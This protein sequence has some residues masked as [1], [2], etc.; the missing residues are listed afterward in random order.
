MKKYLLAAAAAATLALLS[1]CATPTPYAPAD[2]TSSRTYRPGYSET[3]LEEGRFRLVFAGND[4]TSRDTVETYLLYRSAELTLTEGYDWFEIVTRDTA[5]KKR[6]VYTDP[7]PS[8]GG[9]SWRYY[10]RSRWTSWGMGF[11]DFDA[12]EYTRYEAAAE[13]VM[14]KGTKPEDN[15]AAYDARSIKANLEP[16]IIRPAPPTK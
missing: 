15:T 8:Y 16:K 13:I 4:L 11:N 1:A 5:E 10:G 6:T 7:F 2:L 9:M 3:K 14:H 12:E